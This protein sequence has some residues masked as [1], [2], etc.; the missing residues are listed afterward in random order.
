MMAI[1]ALRAVIL[2]VS[3][4]AECDRGLPVAGLGE[5]DHVF[6]GIQHAG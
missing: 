3:G 2:R 6:N 4:V 1:G 5:D